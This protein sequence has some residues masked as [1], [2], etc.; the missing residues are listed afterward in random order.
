MKAYEF[1]RDVYH[2]K[3]DFLIQ[4]L[5]EIT[6]Y[7]ILEKGDIIV[8]I[9]CMQKEIY[10]LESGIVRG[11]LLDADGNE[12]TDCFI[13]QKGQIALAN[14]RIDVEAVS[15]LRIEV[16]IRSCF[17]C[18]PIREIFGMIEQYQEITL[19]YVRLLIEAMDKQWQLKKVLNQCTAMQ[20]YQWFIEEYP[21]LIRKV[22]HRHIASFLGMTPVTLSRL[23]RA[24]REE[25]SRK[26]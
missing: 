23:R 11:T 13:F 8:D 12:I 3:N 20:R 9:G 17:F 24:I 18:L 16:A 15:P 5:C 14:S 25:H 4:Q 2:L 19:T 1:Y 22:N 7:R 21:G 26:E 10:L 6:N